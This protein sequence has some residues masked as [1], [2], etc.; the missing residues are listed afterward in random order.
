MD[1]LK[2]LL[3]RFFSS[4]KAT[5]I[6]ESRPLEPI[7]KPSRLPP[8]LTIKSYD[9]PAIPDIVLRPATPEDKFELRLR[10]FVTECVGPYIILHRSKPQMRICS[11]KA[12]GHLEVPQR[13]RRKA[14]TQDEEA[15]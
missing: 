10:D 15:D 3:S 6:Q 13:R 5:D 8:G 14:K 1:H 4:K 11:P 2:A 12:V 9:D 7:H